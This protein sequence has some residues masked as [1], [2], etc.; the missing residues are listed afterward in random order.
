MVYDQLPV[1]DHFRRITDDV[2]LCV[3]DKKGDPADFYFHLTRVP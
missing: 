1:I 3:M 2:L